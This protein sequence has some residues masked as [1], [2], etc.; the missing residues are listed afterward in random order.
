MA[1]KSGKVILVLGI[2]VMLVS[3]CAL[4]NVRMPKLVQSTPLVDSA[5]PTAEAGLPTAPT[6]LAA[7]SLAPAATEAPQPPVLVEAQPQPGSVLLPKDS[8]TFYFS[9]PM[10]GETVQRGLEI[11]PP[12]AARFEWQDE[13]TLRLTPEQPLPAST[14]LLLRFNNNVRSQAGTFLNP[15]VELTYRTAEPLQLL[16]QLPRPGSNAANPTSAVVAVFSQPVVPLV[17]EQA[18]RPVGFSLEPQA[19]GMGEWLNTT[20]YIFY[21]QPALQGGSQYTVRVNR[22]L[23]GLPDA[24]WS[25]RT[26][27]PQ[28]TLL[29]PTADKPANLDAPI[30]VEFNQPVERAGVEQGLRVRGPNGEALTGT[31]QWNED[32]TTV[33]FQPSALLERDAL[34]LVDL[35]AG[36][37]GLSGGLEQDLNAS[38]RTVPDFTVIWSR[39]A[40]GELLQIYETSYSAVTLRFSAPLARQPLEDLVSFTPPIGDMTLSVDDTVNHLI[41]GGYFQPATSYSLVLDGDLKDRWGQPLGENYLF[42]FRTTSA[43]P[44]LTIPALQ[45]GM[46]TI[47]LLP[48]DTVLPARATNVQTVN[49]SSTRLDLA[50]FLELAGNLYDAKWPAPASRWEETVNTPQ[51]R[52]EEIEIPLTANGA[53]LE[54]GLY[55]F[56]ISSPQTA[57][58][59]V[60]QLS[61]FL[62]VV[63]NTALNLKRTAGEV[64]VWAV[65]APT[66]QA[67]NGLEVGLYDSKGTLLGSAITENGVASIRVPEGTA[68]Y[69]N[70]FVISGQPGDAD[71]S[72]STTAWNQGTPT[73]DSGVRFDSSADQPTAYLYTDRPIYRPGQ[74]VSFRAIARQPQ[75]GRY[76][77]LDRS[78]LTVRVTAP[79][80]GGEPQIVYEKALPL[81]E[82]GAVQDT[83]TLPEDALP[84]MYFFSIVD[85]P[86]ATLA[87]QVALY[88]KPTMDV[89][90]TFP[91]SEIQFGQPLDAAVSARYYFG[92]PAGGVPVNW[93][94]TAMSEWVSLP[95]GYQSGKLD[96]SWLNPYLLDSRMGRYITDGT[97][98][99]AP[100]GSLEIRVENGLLADVLDAEDDYR[101]TLEVTALDESQLPVSAREEITLHP[102]QVIIGVRPDSWSG[103]AGQETGFDVQVFDRAIQPGGEAPLSALY[104]K[105]VY[106]TSAYTSPYSNRTV[107]AEY[108]T[109][110][111]VDFSTGADGRARLA[112]TPP[113]P[114]TYLLEVR[115]QG[116][117]TQVMQW[118]GGEGSAPWPQLPSQKLRLTADAAQY[119]PGQTAHIFIPN[120]YTGGATALLTV[121]RSEIMRWQ[122][123]EITGS[124]LTVDLPLEDVDAPNVFVSVLLLGQNSAGRPDFQMGY[125]ELAVDPTEELLKVELAGQ[126]QRA[127]P[128]EAVQ[129]A[130]RV[131]DAAGKPVQGAFSLALADKAALA[132]A[133]PNSQPINQFFYGPRPLAVMT[134]APLAAYGRRLPLPA[135]GRGGGGGGAAEDTG[136]RDEF[137]DTAFWNGAIVTDANGFAQV[138][139]DLPDNLTTWVADVRGV[140]GDTRTGQATLE[141]TA[142]KLLMVQPVTPRF[143]VRGDH[144][145][146]SALVIN[147]TDQPIDAEVSL[148]AT[149]FTF[150]APDQAVQ[151][152]SLPAG[153]RQAVDWWGTAQVADVASLVFRATGGGLTDSATPEG[154]D[155]PVLTFSAPATFGTAG[156]LDAAGARQ[157][158]VAV[159]RSFTPTGGSLDVELSPSLAAALVGGLQVVETYTERDLPVTLAS[160]LLPNLEAYRTLADLGADNPGLKTSLDAAIQEGVS[161]LVRSQND[162]GGWGWSEDSQSDPYQS[163]YILLALSRAQ[164]AGVDVADGVIDRAR[165]YVYAALFPSGEQTAWE[166]QRLVFMTW[167]LAESGEG[168]DLPLNTLAGWR[169][170]L[171][172]WAKALLMLLLQPTDA[173]TAALLE[174]DV[175]DAAVRTATGVHWE[176]TANGDR[177]FGSTAFTSAVVT[178]A[179]ART[180]PADPI[181]VDAVRY[182][183]AT[184]DSRGGWYSP[185]DTAWTLIAL[186]QAL[187]G[188][189]DIHSDYHFSASL[190]NVP[191]A[192]GQAGGDNAFNP[193]TA[194]VPLV[195]LR[196]DTANAL[197]IERSEGN[198]RLYYR[199]YLN[200]DR[201]VEGAQPVN[202]GMT[203]SRT[204]TLMDTNGCAEPGCPPATEAK[205]GTPAPVV[206]V[207]LS[208]TLEHDASHLVVEDF[209]PAGAEIL[210]TS[211]KTSQ[212]LNPEADAPASPEEE[213]DPRR[214]FDDGWGWWF[215]HSPR[216]YDDHIRW[217]AQD[218]PAG[219]YQLVYRLVLLQPG[220]YRVIPAHAYNYFFPEVQGASAGTIFTIRP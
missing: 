121:E 3:A 165:E 30:V 54:P 126:P 143:L 131:T 107:E 57:N 14:D 198:G 9:Q 37:L 104:R 146:L 98:V 161:G 178:Y 58:Q 71:F 132:L 210:N 135:T 193:V 49:I 208:L 174:Q 41:I 205:M 36:S 123:L 142:S 56:N 69:E 145:A 169:S 191:L 148:Q 43:V 153:G 173:Q 44:S 67:I 6:T 189:G 8:L 214:P 59:P 68:V 39:P 12:V 122:Q 22:E 40:R 20:T 212:Q 111:S 89:Q 150:D 151:R 196:V 190:N 168:Y 179:L 152:V 204:Y 105:V 15:V 94:L 220:E 188:T 218:V 167:V 64:F 203:V 92:A 10:D 163:A 21:P 216:V 75:N 125:V 160:R 129:F 24:D 136:V 60:Y 170:D 46:S 4:P 194:S 117:V 34:Y 53:N 95:E 97:G 35:P 133:D 102:S 103:Q 19:P 120:P 128:G 157:E 11:N 215:F 83:F 139:A 5:T 113:E 2:V 180:D 29:A 115:G 182:L 47:F 16:E 114:G 66:Q 130:L 91:Q 186:S 99:T 32:D 108:T 147:N 1:T 65:N 84:G 80:T 61:P 144:A 192:D 159:P 119:T 96:T 33:T 48:A 116:A 78:E 50:G 27:R 171:S 138:T 162:D 118:V 79:F 55:A 73:W 7:P 154:G 185:Y 140:D 200:V 202:R 134:S 183:V 176:D 149:G 62:A 63:S 201:P 70:L 175:K 195:D 197:R 100:D 166:K 187:K 76:S 26:S 88:R 211:L 82:F 106:K 217:T 28:A 109:V 127:A 42:E 207:R 177:G 155:L 52:N 45:A 90:V 13:S 77:L 38:F 101:L 81:S 181:L 172:P 209:I 156:M 18:N 31:F 87:F 219:T 158:L 184:R 25:F 206:L 199:A 124:S 164:Q 23:T 17:G 137:A 86:R 93:T 110:G 85:I 213:I 141:I 112:F 51:D 72:L 74:Q